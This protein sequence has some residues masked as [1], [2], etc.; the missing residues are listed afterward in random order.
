ML[1]RA[2][3]PGRGLAGHAGPVHLG[4]TRDR[5]RTPQEAAAARKTQESSDEEVFLAARSLESTDYSPH[6]FGT[7]IVLGGGPPAVAPH[8]GPG[9]AGPGRAGV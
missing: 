1:D 3:P 2:A 6:I 9:R 7:H 5:I 8:P 4:L